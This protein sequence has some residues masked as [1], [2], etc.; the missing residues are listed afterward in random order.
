MPELCW[1]CRLPLGNQHSHDDLRKSRDHVIPRSKGGHSVLEGNIRW[2]HRW[3]NSARGHAEVTAKMQRDFK[4]RMLQE[5]GIWFQFKKG[6]HGVSTELEARLKKWLDRE[7]NLKRGERE[8]TI[9]ITCQEGEWTVRAEDHT[10]RYQY[11]HSFEDGTLKT[12]LQNF[13]NAA[14]ANARKA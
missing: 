11:W 6:S 3:C 10:G 9:E 14:E 2:A 7:P 12:T 4:T 13:L 1:I 5:H 8:P